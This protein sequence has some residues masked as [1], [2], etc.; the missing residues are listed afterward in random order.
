M[1][2]TYVNINVANTVIQSYWVILSNRY[3]P[4]PSYLQPVQWTRAVHCLGEL[5]GRSD[6]ETDCGQTTTPARPPR[7]VKGAPKE[8]YAGSSLLEEAYFGV[9]GA[10]KDV[11]FGPCFIGNWV[12]G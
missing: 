10:K 11:D 5:A 4:G 3:R 1:I 6:A 12:V 8:G 9:T 2:T 7:L